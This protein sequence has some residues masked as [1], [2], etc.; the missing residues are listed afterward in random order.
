MALP[1]EV[2]VI[3]DL[4]NTLD[5]EDGSEK[6]TSPAAL[7]AW[8]SDRDLI[9][10]SDRLGSADLARVVELR[11]ALRDLLAA[12]GGEGPDPSALEALNRACRSV[13]L[14]VSFNLSGRPS[15]GPESGG[16]EG[17]LARLLAILHRSEAEGS[18]DRLKVC[19]EDSCRWAFYDQSRNR[20]RS[21]CSMAVCGNRNKARAFRSRTTGGG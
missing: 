8:L 17:V 3:L 2:L 9:G 20:S 11:E 12:R 16:I 5:L 7:E 21:W 1:S 19:A 13:R 18:L 15:L 4:L 10:P 6:L 14:V